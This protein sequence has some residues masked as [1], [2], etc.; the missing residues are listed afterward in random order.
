MPRK[1]LFQHASEIVDLYVNHRKNC[2][3][4]AAAVG[5]S[6][7]GVHKLLGD[8]G[9]PKR[10]RSEAKVLCAKRG[11][12]NPGFKTGRRPDGYAVRRFNGK[13][14]LQHREVAESLMSRPLNANEVVHH[15]NDNRG[16]N[17]GSNLWVF[18]SQ[19]DHARFHKNGHVSDHTIFVA[20]EW[21]LSFGSPW[22]MPWLA[23]NSATLV[24]Q[25]SV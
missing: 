15:C 9:V 17:R 1:L 3:E 19:A 18:A 20:A 22:N 2:V 11:A 10:S 24:T 23:D 21:V 8:I 6:P 14:V 25:P 5:V 13:N 16:D 7:Q 4:I 12:E